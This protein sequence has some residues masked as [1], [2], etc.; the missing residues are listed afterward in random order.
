M[1]RLH[2]SDRLALGIVLLVAGLGFT[3]HSG[4]GAA[5]VSPEEAPVEAPALAPAPE[6]APVCGSAVPCRANPRPSASSAPD[7]S[8]A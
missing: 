3:L 7:S 4:T 1:F 6:P 5:T 2:R 8:R